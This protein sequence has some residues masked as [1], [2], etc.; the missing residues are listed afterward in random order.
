MKRAKRLAAYLTIACLTLGSSAVVLA[1]ETAPAEDA[2]AEVTA[3][4]APEKTYADLEVTEKHYFNDRSEDL[5]TYPVVKG[6]AAL[7]KKMFDDLFKNYTYYERSNTSMYDQNAFK[8][9]FVV[10]NAGRYAKV[11]VIYNY[12]QNTRYSQPVSIDNFYYIDKDTMTTMTADAYTA[13]IAVPAPAVT[14]APVDEEKPAEEEAI[15]LPL[16][17]YA[18]PLGYELSFDQE[19]GVCKITKGDFITSIKIDDNAY[20]VKNEKVELEAA[21]SMQDGSIYVPVSFFEKVL[22]ATVKTDADGNVEVVAAEIK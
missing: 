5:G 15:M 20:T 21:P 12:Q 19:T 18:E 4:V 22:G 1:E 3:T 17:K 6:M 7:N 8:V 11:N 10:E 16:R 14:E 2:K 13:A 9:E